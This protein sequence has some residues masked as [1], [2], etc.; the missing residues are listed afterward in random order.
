MRKMFGGHV[1][2]SHVQL[3]LLGLF[4]EV[5]LLLRQRIKAQPALSG[6]FLL[7]FAG[8]RLSG[9][10]AVA[11]YPS[12]HVIYQRLRL[13]V[14]RY[15]AKRRLVDCAAVSSDE[16]LVHFVVLGRRSPLVLP[17]LVD[18]FQDRQKALHTHHAVCVGGV[19][20]LEELEHAGHPRFILLP[21]G[22]QLIQIQH[23]EDLLRPERHH[24]AQP[25]E[26]A[27]HRA[28]PLLGKHPAR[29]EPCGAVQ[30]EGKLVGC[31]C[32]QVA[33][34]PCVADENLQ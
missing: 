11:K 9:S 20:L 32:Q 33:G 8:L 18:E 22:H 1:V 31:D 6:V 27:P 3:Q 7:R 34:F 30:P 4:G 26:R 28:S 2:R 23:H 14:L 25:K 12:V 19:E 15:F 10:N 24:D 16:V 21:F 5:G 29:I 13:S 17:G